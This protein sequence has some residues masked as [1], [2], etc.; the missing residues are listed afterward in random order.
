MVQVVIVIVYL[1]RRKL[2]FVNDVLGGQRAD[3][4]PFGKSTEGGMS[5]EDQT[6]KLV[7]TDMV[8]VAC[9]RSTYN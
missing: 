9:L 5:I 6:D 2:P 8:C 1:G 4:E 3:V 7:E